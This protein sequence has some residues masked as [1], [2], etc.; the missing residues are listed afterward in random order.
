MKQNQL[1]EELGILH[2]LEQPHP[3]PFP[4]SKEGGKKNNK[5]TS[6]FHPAYG[7]GGAMHK[8]ATNR[9]SSS[10]SQVERDGR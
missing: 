5:E 1:Q 4:A 6:H 7:D 9:A 8:Y 2:E 3:Q 10:M